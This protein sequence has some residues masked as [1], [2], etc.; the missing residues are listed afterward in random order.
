MH[1]AE[2]FLRFW[3]I[4]PLDVIVMA[5]AFIIIFFIVIPII[6]E[7]VHIYGNSMFITV[8]TRPHHLSQPQ[9]DKSNSR[10]PVFNIHFNIILPYFPRPVPLQLLRF[11]PVNITPPTLHNHLPIRLSP[12]L[13]KLSIWQRR[14][15]I[16]V[17]WDNAT[18][19]VSYDQGCR[20]FPQT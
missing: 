2:W 8:F 12:I 1:G 10:H 17:H 6:K 15:I 20:N 18:T 14:Q 3:Q 16:H 7:I 11:L 13:H 5:H 4:P 19:A 9:P